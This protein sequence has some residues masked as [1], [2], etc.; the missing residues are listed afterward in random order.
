VR[1]AACILALLTLAGPRPAGTFDFAQVRSLDS[2]QAGA[3]DLN[4]LMEKVLARRDENWKRLQ[5]YVLDEREEME[6]RGPGNR[7]VWGETREF[8]WYL[9]DGFFVRSPLQVNG[10]TVGEADRR[11]YEADY[12]KRVKDR[13]A[14]SGGSAQAPADVQ[15]LIQQTRQPQFIDTAYF[16]KF[17]FEPS[18]YALVGREDFE[19]REVLRIEYYP[20]QLFRHE[21]E[22]QQRRAELNESNPG[23]DR[24]A[25]MERM[26]NKVAL[27]TLW[28]DPR[29][30]QIVKYT[31]D[32]VNL[33][34]LPI[35]WFVHMDSARAVMTMGQPMPDVWLPRDV[36]MRVSA[37][38]AIGSFDVR[39]R[40]DY[41]N[42]RRADTDSRFKV[43]ER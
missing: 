8:T 3:G 26:M 35:A 9:R 20:S 12:L 39:Y 11:K 23:R 32:N 30:S 33:E 34:F 2:A 21:Q 31:F 28:V 14:R 42:Y 22:M 40:V 16:L 29:A 37:T 1:V 7:P 38:L 36:D 19:G 27:V 24:K 10:V 25:A 43:I 5:Q 18:R 41:T 4:A 17:R 15:S 6:I 13:D